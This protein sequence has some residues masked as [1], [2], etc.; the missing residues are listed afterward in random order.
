MRKFR[1]LL[2][3]F[4]LL[5]FASS[6]RS[7]CNTFYDGFE[8]GSYT[9]TWGSAGGTYTTSVITTNPAVGTYCLSNSG[10]GGHLS[11]LV[12]TFPSGTPDNVSWRVRYDATSSSGGYV[13]LGDASATASDCI[14]FCYISGGSNVRF[15]NGTGVNTPCTANQ[16]IEIEMRNIDYVNRRYDF[17]INGTLIQSNYGF[18][19]TTMN[20]MDR[21]YLYNISSMSAYYDEITIGGSSVSLS[22]TVMDNNCFGDS[23]GMITAIPAGG[24]PNYTYLWNT[25]DTTATISNLAAGTYTVDV[26]DSSGCTAVDSFTIAEPSAIA[27]A[28]TGVDP[29][30]N[31]DS[32]GSVDLSASG[33]TPGYTYLWSNGD[34]TEDLSGIPAGAYS[35]MISDSNGC[36][37]QDSITLTEPT[38][39]VA[40]FTA[41]DPLC[42]GDSTGSIDLSPSGGTPGYTYLWST[43]DST[44]D[45]SG[46]AGGTYVINVLD[47]IGCLGSASI[48]LTDPAAISSSGA[49]TDEVT[50]PGSNGAIDL[51][52]SGGNPGY[53]FLWSNGATTEDLSGLTAGTYSVQITDSNGCM[54]ADT[55]MISVIVDVVN[56]L[57]SA[58]IKAYPN[59]GNGDFN[60]LITQPAGAPAWLQV[61]DLQGKLLHQQQVNLS[62]GENQIRLDLTCEPQGVYLLKMESAGGIQYLKLIRQ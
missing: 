2:S 40:A 21:I 39:V 18:R 27:S 56:E 34:T 6:A 60:L 45:L 57:E 42:N 4:I 46:L 61:H 16:W 1:L 44:Q 17:Y 50:P 55:F 19:S 52:V 54:W 48:T 5:L 32:S 35:V 36:M 59:P 51:T 3:V 58:S 13:V 53:S 7:Q 24:T 12:A 9:P 22:A 38:A 49:L 20:T 47:S 37:Y 43:G 62:A 30:C 10:S 33:G 23:T 25:G 14:A 26:V 11:G 29:I 31:G 15:Y 8:S 28:I 41:M